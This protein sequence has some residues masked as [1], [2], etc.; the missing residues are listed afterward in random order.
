MV[1]PVVVVPEI[2]IMLVVK[3][4][5]LLIATIGSLFVFTVPTDFSVSGLK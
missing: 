1:V 4:V 2:P 5:G 3:E